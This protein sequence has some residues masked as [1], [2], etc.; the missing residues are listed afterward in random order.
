MTK[1]MVRA[2]EQDVKRSA[3]GCFLELEKCIS[4]YD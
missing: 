4:G 3:L 2:K 1:M